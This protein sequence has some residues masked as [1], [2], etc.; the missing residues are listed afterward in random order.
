LTE[1]GFSRPAAERAVITISEAALAFQTR[2]GGKVQRYLRSYGEIMLKDLDSIFQF[3]RLGRDEMRRAFIYWLQNALNMPL[4]FSDQA[5]VQFC[6]ANHITPDEL[7]AAADDLNLNQA[8]VDDLTD[9][10]VR[11]HSNRPTPA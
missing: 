6:E 2:Y 7:S 4:S 9:L 8:V 11:D 5:L 3:S 1:A 10:W